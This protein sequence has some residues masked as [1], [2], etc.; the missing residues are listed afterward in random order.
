MPL[1]QGLKLPASSDGT[2]FVRVKLA[3]RP[4]IAPQM[5]VANNG[6]QITRTWER[7]LDDG[8]TEALDTPKPG[9]LIKVELR[10]TLPTDGSRYLVVEDRLPA[11]FETVDQ[12][13]KSQ[14]AAGAAVRRNWNISHQE[15]RDDRAVFFLD[16][17]P[18]RGTYT[19]NYLAR[20]TLA[21]K[22]TAPP[23]KVESMYDPE[24]V[25]LSASRTFK[26]K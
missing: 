21:G 2:A 10:V 1:Q 6:M 25:A 23:A 20:C 24:N 26:T 11:I 5:P 4:Q 14:A 9:D 7:V 12:R 22:A 18:T 19:I 13:F 8:T 17:V 16:W 3:A 15:L